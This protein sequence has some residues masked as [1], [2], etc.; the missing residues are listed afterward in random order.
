LM[1]YGNRYGDLPSYLTNSLFKIISILKRECRLKVRTE[2]EISQ[3]MISWNSRSFI[4]TRGQAS[5][6]YWPNQVSQ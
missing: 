4:T 5:R 1:N 6:F 3:W 2:E